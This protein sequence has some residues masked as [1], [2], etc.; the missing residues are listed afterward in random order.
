M[1]YFPTLALAKYFYKMAATTGPSCGEM[2][3]KFLKQELCVL[4]SSPRNNWMEKLDCVNAI[5]FNDPEK[6]LY[7]NWIKIGSCEL[8]FKQ[9]VITIDN[10]HLKIVI[11]P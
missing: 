6:I 3:M 5:I 4:W 10:S 2:V 1:S 7:D 8:A 9:S 11:I